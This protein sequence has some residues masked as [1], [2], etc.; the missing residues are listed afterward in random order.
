MAQLDQ[1]RELDAKGIVDRLP[2]MGRDFFT[3][4]GSFLHLN[5]DTLVAD[6]QQGLK[7][8]LR[9]SPDGEFV[10]L[11]ASVFERVGNADGGDL[12]AWRGVTADLLANTVFSCWVTSEVCKLKRLPQEFEHTF[13]SAVHQTINDHWDYVA[14]LD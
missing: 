11:V 8:A 6:T 9:R 1:V 13:T 10:P 14:T 7:D 4:Q 12:T 3:V 2:G 5:N